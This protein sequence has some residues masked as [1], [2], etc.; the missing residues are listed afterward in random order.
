MWLYR[1]FIFLSTELNYFAFKANSFS[2]HWGK[3]GF[4]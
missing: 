2:N 1:V 4:N 3:Y